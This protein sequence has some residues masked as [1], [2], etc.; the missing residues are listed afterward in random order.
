MYSVPEINVQSNDKQTGSLSIT[1]SL[2][3]KER[4]DNFAKYSLSYAVQ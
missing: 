3:M 2:L 4:A 1:S